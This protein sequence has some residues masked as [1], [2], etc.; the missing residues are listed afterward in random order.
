MKAFLLYKDRDFD[1][2][3]LLPRRDKEVGTRHA[4]RAALDLAQLLP[5]NHA[6]LIADLGLDALIDAMAGDDRF[7]RDVATAVLLSGE[8]DPAAIRYRQAI[9]ADCVGNADVVRGIYRIAVEANEGARKSWSFFSR[10][11]AGILY[12]A[13]ETLEMFT[14]LLKEL[15]GIADENAGAFASEGFIRLFAMLKEELNDDYFATI[16]NHLMQ[17]KFRGGVLLSARLGPG[18]KGTDYV[19]RQPNIDPRGWLARLFADG[20][21]QF[22]FHL[23][24]RDEAGARA[25]SVLRDTGVNLVANALA[26][27][28]DHILSFFQMLRTELA[29]YLA[30]MNLEAALHRRGAPICMP[31][32]EP[33]GSRKLSFSGLYDASL[34]LTTDAAVI[35]NDVDADGKDIVVVTGANTGGKSTF[36]RSV[37][38]AQVMMQ[39]GM[40]TPATAFR[41]ETSR[42]I[43]THYKREEDA[44]MTSGKWDEE[45]VRMS[46]IVDR[47]GADGMVL[48][49]ESFAST[50]E[51]E[52]SEIA[53]QIVRA[54]RARNVKVV[55]VT[56]LYHFARG[57]FEEKL[58]TALFL[59]AERRPDGSRPFKLVEA[60]PLE[61]SYGEDLYRAIF[62]RGAPAAAVLR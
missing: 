10:Y 58:P 47:I 9:Y 38:I 55:F 20:P 51:R 16:A 50:N 8:T 21:P 18:S 28:A 48:F 41:A 43:A 26:Q 39:A 11:P 59:R 6:E 15:R 37:G 52:G 23:H 40:F 61:S 1:L 60:E 42:G 62:A 27:S 31:V 4:D 13:V 5:W 45:L 57:I 56:H 33:A 25:L 44:S 17:A 36:L 19:L 24:P 53:G 29:F 7:L 3:Q 2:D 49:N 14:K 32:P 12:R 54:L 35:G 22:T 34:R 30:G 46:A